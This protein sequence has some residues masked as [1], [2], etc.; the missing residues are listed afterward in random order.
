MDPHKHLCASQG[1]IRA[2][3]R[4]LVTCAFDVLVVIE[5]TTTAIEFISDYDS[6]FEIFNELDEVGGSYNVAAG[7]SQFAD[8]E[9]GESLRYRTRPNPNGNRPPHRTAIRLAI[10]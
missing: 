5:A 4:L 1:L 9:G 8:I 10:E 3:R 6:V 7:E 2:R